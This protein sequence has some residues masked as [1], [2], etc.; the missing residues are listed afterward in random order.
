MR[1]GG[2]KMTIKKEI[3]KELNKKITIDWIANGNGTDFFDRSSLEEQSFYDRNKK[4]IWKIINKK[5]RLIN[6]LKHDSDTQYIDDH[7]SFKS[8]LS[9][10]SVECVAK[11]IRNGGKK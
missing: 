10:L 6:F 5:G 4:E 7:N 8:V 2:K 11:K 1:N 9:W 3:V